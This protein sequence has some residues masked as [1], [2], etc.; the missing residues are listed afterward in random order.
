MTQIVLA[1]QPVRLA[2]AATAFVMMARTV[3]VVRTIV[4]ESLLE[5][6]RTGIAAATKCWKDLRG[7][8]V[9]AT[10]I[11]SLT[12]FEQVSDIRLP[13]V[14]RQEI[15]VPACQM[16]C[17]DDFFG[18]NEICKTS[19]IRLQRANAKRG[20]EKWCFNTEMSYWNFVLILNKTIKVITR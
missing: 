14:N 12:W 3:R 5:S 8:A 11:I 16:A 20:K 18:E 4:T 13:A 15:G 1:I 6:R 19:S 9:S 17:G 2:S 7:T 10:G